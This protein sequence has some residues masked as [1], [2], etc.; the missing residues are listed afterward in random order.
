MI[1]LSGGFDPL[2]IGH[3]RMI[4][5]AAKVDKVLIILNSDAWLKRKKGY[6]FMPWEERC[7]ILLNLE[8]VEYVVPV[9]DSDDTV[10]EA[11]REHRAGVMYFGNGGDRKNENTPEVA[12]CEELDIKLVWN[13][14]GEKA[15][16]SSELVARAMDQLGGKQ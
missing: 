7:E 12:L 8:N 5:D 15:Q 14:G 4:N 16:S 1:A 9:D 13:L 11:L 3:L 10:C 6:V 2:H